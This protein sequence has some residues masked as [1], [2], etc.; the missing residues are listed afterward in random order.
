MPVRWGRTSNALRALP[1]GT[2]LGPKE[3]GAHAESFSHSPEQLERS[4]VCDRT[5]SYKTL[6]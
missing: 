3:G 5:I 6:A 4:Q 2:D 1:G